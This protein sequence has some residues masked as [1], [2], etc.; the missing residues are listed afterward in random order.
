MRRASNIIL[1]LVIL[2]IGVLAWDFV[3]PKP[4]ISSPI[5]GIAG[6]KHIPKSFEPR[7]G[8][9]LAQQLAEHPDQTPRE[10]LSRADMRL[11]MEFQ[12]TRIKELEAE[13]SVLRAS[14]KSSDLR[15]AGN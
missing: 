11:I 13:L 4:I 12:A 7:I 2:C 5:V 8:I 14:T 15:Y 6:I 9:P 1:I 10:D 3:R